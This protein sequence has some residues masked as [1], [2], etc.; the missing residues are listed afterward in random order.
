MEAACHI[1][2][3]YKRQKL[4]VWATFIITILSLCYFRLP[5]DVC[6]LTASPKSTLSRAL[7]LIGAVAMPG[8][9]LRQDYS[10]KLEVSDFARLDKKLGIRLTAWGAQDQVKSSSLAVGGLLVNASS[11]SFGTVRHLLS[12]PH[13]EGL[14]KLSRG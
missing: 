10:A 3:V 5:L 8:M 14:G 2:M 1:C 6:N 7:C 13:L 11:N 12:P 9:V 4:Q